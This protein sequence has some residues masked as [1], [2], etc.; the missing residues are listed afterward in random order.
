MQVHVLD[1]NILSDL[2]ARNKRVVAQFV[3]HI[4]SEGRVA[5][6]DVNIIERLRGWQSMID[7]TP[8]GD[9]KSLAKH[10]RRL[11]QVARSLCHFRV[12]H[13]TESALRGVDDIQKE[14]EQMRLTGENRPDDRDMLIVSIMREHPSFVLV[15]HNTRHFLPFLR[16]HQV[17][18]WP[19]R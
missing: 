19:S 8:D 4:Q 3:Q 14:V 5:I 2:E 1:T 11:G 17:K 7:K 18:D 13:V 16:T 9:L 12:I 15:T 6:T 10:Y